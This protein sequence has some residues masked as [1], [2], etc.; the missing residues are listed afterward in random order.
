MMLTLSCSTL[1]GQTL[2]RPSAGP[3]FGQ[4]ASAQEPRVFAPGIVSRQYQ[5]LNAAFSPDGST[6]F[7]TIADAART[8]Y[9][10]VFTEKSAGGEWSPLAVAP[11]SGTYADAD[12]TFSPDGKRLYFISKRPRVGAPADAKDF[13]LWYVE[14]QGTGWGAP[15][16]VGSDVNTP[17]DDYY[18][19]VT[20]DGVLYW[21]RNSKIVRAVPDGLKFRVEELP[22]IVNAPGTMQLDP[23]VAADESYVIFG[24]FGRADQLGSADLY[25][26]FRIEGRWQAPKSLG[27][28]IN[29]AAFE[30]CPA[31]SPDGQYF[32]FTSYRVSEQARPK[33]R[34]EL[35]QIVN[36]F[37]QTENGLGNVYW[38]RADFIEKMR[39]EATAGAKSL[40]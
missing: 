28:T 15:V 38:M 34:R 2:V 20:R 13:N 33:G 19:S 30:Y 22:E 25:I 40:P 31:V 32:F 17:A 1:S 14:R 23:F 5:E 18:V 24:S 16:D 26:S 37:D 8:H 4:A 21:S 39:R 9:T 3:Y 29:S 7:F 10:L 6:F 36:D 27:S 35:Q 12:P 11:F